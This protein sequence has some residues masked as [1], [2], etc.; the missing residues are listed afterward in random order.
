[1]VKLLRNYS[2]TIFWVLLSILRSSYGTVLG[3][4]GELVG[5]ELGS[6]IPLQLSFGIAAQSYGLP[7]RELV[8]VFTLAML[9]FSIYVIA[10]ALDVLSSN[11]CASS[12]I[13]VSSQS[14]NC[15]WLLNRFL[16]ISFG[17]SGCTTSD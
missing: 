8:C 14:V 17:A 9:M 4:R 16:M 3:H 5:V 13:G 6:G 11:I 7:T 15:V 10:I 2:V 1:M 12:V